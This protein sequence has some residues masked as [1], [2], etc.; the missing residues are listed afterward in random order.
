LRQHAGSEDFAR[1][2]L[3]LD[4]GLG[5][6][7]RAALLPARDLHRN[8]A[9]RFALVVAV[10]RGDTVV[11]QRARG[12][13]RHA[14]VAG[15]ALAARAAHHV[16][17]LVVLVGAHQA[18][19]DVGQVEGDAAF[20]RADAL[21]QRERGVEQGLVVGLGARV[22]RHSVGGVGAD[23]ER[24][25]HRRQQQPQQQR[26][27]AALPRRSAHWTSAYSSSM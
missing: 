24:E 11:G 22:G 15:D 9:H 6:R 20:L 14:D 16:I 8:H 4:G 7:H 17:D 1:Q 27:Q 3:A 21:A 18:L 25:S 19:G 5:H 12:R 23:G 13:A 26:A 10:I 2:A